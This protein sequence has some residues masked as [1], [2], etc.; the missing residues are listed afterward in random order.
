M[1]NTHTQTAT[2]QM[3]TKY[4]S[5]RL[6]K[7]LANFKLKDDVITKL[8]D[9]VL[10]EGLEIKKFDVCIY[11]ICVD[12]FT[13]KI[14]RL[15]PVFSKSDIARLEVFPYGIIDWDRFHVRVGFAVDELAGVAGNTPGLG[16]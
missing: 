8:A 16:R 5:Q 15:E 12:Y 10:I 3:N 2:T 11:G 13:D 14:P 7:R 9:R 6:S 4:L 1:A